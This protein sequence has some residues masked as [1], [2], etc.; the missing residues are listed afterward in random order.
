[1][2]LWILGL[3]LLA[4]FRDGVTV[5][6]V[7]TPLRETFPTPQPVLHGDAYGLRTLAWA[8]G[9]DQPGT[10]VNLSLAVLAVVVVLLVWSS[11]DL[12]DAQK[13]KVVLLLIVSGPIVATLLN[14]L[15]TNDVF[16]VL[17]GLIIARWGTSIGLAML[18]S[19]VMSFGN[20][21][22]A[23]TATLAVV[24]L[25]LVS[26]FRGFRWPSVLAC[27]Q[28]L[29]LLVIIGYWSAANGVKSQAA[30][31]PELI[32]PSLYAY[33]G[34][35]PLSLY[36]GFGVVWVVVAYAVVVSRTSDRIPLILA[37]FV[38]PTVA[39]LATLDQTRVFVGIST[40]VVVI[41]VRSYVPEMMD[42]LKAFGVKSILSWSLGLALLCPIVLIDFKARPQLPY[43]WLLYAFLPTVK[44]HLLG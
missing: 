42:K 11:R 33:L 29:I 34:N 16:V 23:F 38:V 31:L 22:Q 8:L 43:E 21:G 18:G 26:R 44:A 9:A 32:S 30:Y 27:S 35:L 41:L 6:D 4:L 5:I 13:R 24:L 37:A 10:Y 3:G 17:G 20:P 19:L 1:L 39:T 28:A 2:W 12:R 15:G 40:A 14:Q 36:A 7:P 25:S